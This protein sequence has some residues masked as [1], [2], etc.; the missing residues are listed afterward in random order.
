[1][2]DSLEGLD[3]KRGECSYYVS[4]VLADVKKS[5]E[6]GDLVKVP[7]E[8]VV[9]GDVVV[10]GW[11]SHL[12]ISD[13]YVTRTTITPQNSRRDEQGHILDPLILIIPDAVLRRKQKEYL[14]SKRE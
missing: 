14:L 13:D 10:S 1:M 11:S 3:Y 9:V 12:V 8:D 5:L 6:I 2:Y 7:A 4:Q